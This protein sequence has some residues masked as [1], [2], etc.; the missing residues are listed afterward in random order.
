VA[1]HSFDEQ[2]FGA[3]PVVSSNG[4]TTP[5]HQS[6]TPVTP[7][8]VVTYQI[9]PDN[10]VYGSGS[11]GYRQGETTAAVGSR[12]D[13]DAAALGISTAQ[14]EISPDFVWSYELGSKNRLWGGRLQLDS[15]VY[16]INWK[17]IQSSLTLP[18][19]NVPTV[20]NLGDATSKGIDVALNILA[21]E[22]LQFTLSMGYAD[23]KYTST[24]TGSGG[25]IIRSSGQPLDIPPWQAAASAQYN[26]SAFGR[27]AYARL[28]D[29]VQSHDSTPLDYASAA[30]DPTVPRTPSYNVLG[31]RLGTYIGG[32]DVSLYGTNLGNEHPELTRYR[33]TLTTFNYRGQ[34]LTPL[35]VGITGVFRY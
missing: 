30:T 18:D 24:T 5:S 21:T 32:W 16:W 33:D 28:N 29:Q 6:D 23:A 35:T 8:Y 26:F 31:A 10:M 25:A 17:N 15:S 3:G 12:C 7:K 14:R 11:K 20:A 22:K 4:S 1:H 9:D 19:C 13:A 34:T 2:L 27:K